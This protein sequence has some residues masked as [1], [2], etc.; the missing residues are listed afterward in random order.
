[1]VLIEITKVINAQYGNWA[2]VEYRT[3][4]GT[5]GVCGG[6]F[7]CDACYIVAGQIYRGN[8]SRK[9]TPDGRVRASFNQ[10]KIVSPEAHLLKYAFNM[11]GIGYKDRAAIFSR[12]KV[13]ELI[14]ALQEKKSAELMSIPKIGKKKL[15]DMYASYET[16]RMQL[17]ASARLYK[18]FPLMCNSV[19]REQLLTLFQYFNMNMQELIDFLKADPWRLWYGS[20]YNGFIEI[21]EKE[22]QFKK[23]LRPKTREKLAQNA[24][25]DMKRPQPDPGFKRCQAID[26]IIRHM[27]RTGD[28]WMP[29]R[30]F[31]S[32]MSDRIGPT[33]P[34][35]V[36]EGYIAVKRYA[37][38]EKYL[39]ETLSNIVR[40]YRYT[41]WTPPPETAQLDENQRRALAEAC[42]QPVFILQG[43]AGVGKTTV[44]K[45]I[46]KSLY[47]DVTCAAPTGK[48]A[49]RLT[50]V[51]GVEA[52]TVH[53]LKYMS[54][55]VE[56]DST[57]LL[58]EQSMQEPEVLAELFT[59]RKFSKIIF[60]GDAAQL[61]SVGPGQLFRDLCDSEY[62]KI[63]LTKIYRSGD[64]S[65]IATNG[66]KI[67]V[68]DPCLDESAES[69]IV[70]PYKSAG[71]IVE[72]VSQIYSDTKSMPMVLC[73]TNKEVA[74]LNG[75]LRDLINPIH[76]NPCK[77]AE[78]NM[79][80]SNGEWRY[81]DWRFGKGDAVINIT[82]KYASNGSAGMSLQVANGE[83]GKVIDILGNSISVAFPKQV[84]HTY[85]DFYVHP[86]K[87]NA[88]A[89]ANTR[90]A[91][92]KQQDAKKEEV[93]LV[94]DYLRPAYAL[95]V[96]KAQGS[97]YPV[98][99]VKSTSC[100]GDKRERFYTAITRAKE[101][102]IVYEVGT[103]NTDCIRASPARRKTFF[104]KNTEVE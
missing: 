55:T 40:D 1:M 43:G 101:R 76:P 39:E 59:K 29:L 35:V 90:T 10:G 87:A 57:L 25:L 12:M 4:D 26:T 81:I 47:G 102:C 93:C 48:A 31:R 74:M 37:S 23:T 70:H 34:V 98:V 97:E 38:I 82:N 16:V 75:P 7:G 22:E 78:M 77:S 69:F 103:A 8:I 73:N 83:I 86:P 3:K 27:R 15:L 53:R 14:Y 94:K 41:R 88:N 72:K 62:P 45:H 13:K 104:L 91:G 24:A 33:W 95:T 19:S 79:D 67:R 99:I 71:S 50:E 49:Q 30:D 100:W 66:Q 85:V 9:R 63:E 18:Q 80:Y 21:S 56:V 2:L 28:Y 42:T 89:N 36:R 65:F 54:E 5:R 44:C 61:T 68:G 6:K 51:T 96:N 32:V 58:D 17:D 11:H 84:G 20:E 92:Q 52:Y 46:V 60:V 64:K